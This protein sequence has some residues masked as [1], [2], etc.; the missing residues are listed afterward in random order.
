MFPRT[1]ADNQSMIK[2]ETI[3]EG[4]VKG[5]KYGGGQ[6]LTSKSKTIKTRVRVV[7]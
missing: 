3:S 7:D 4:Y 2:S 5:L 1:M 6:R